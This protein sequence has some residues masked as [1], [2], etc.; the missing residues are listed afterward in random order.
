[1]CQA[2]KSN[3]RQNVLSVTGRYFAH[4]AEIEQLPLL[5]GGTSIIPQLTMTCSP[6]SISQKWANVVKYAYQMALSII[7]CNLNLKN[8]HAHKRKNHQTEPE[9]T[10]HAAW[11]TIITIAMNHSLMP[12][13]Q[14]CILA[15]CDHVVTP[16]IIG[17]LL[18]HLCTRACK[19]SWLEVGVMNLVRPHRS[20]SA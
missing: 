12:Y 13:G 9:L 8:V 11:S 16:S 3:I 18:Y 20:M 7:K 1:M 19:L 2:I 4:S 17:Q 10:L 14:H 5:W 6:P 15:K